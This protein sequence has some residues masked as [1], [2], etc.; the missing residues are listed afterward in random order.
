MD[1][2]F[3]FEG[4]LVMATLAEHRNTYSINTKESSASLN[5]S[6]ADGHISTQE[7]LSDTN[8]VQSTHKVSENSNG[9]I[10]K[11]ENRLTGKKGRVGNRRSGKS[12][13]WKSLQF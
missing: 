8:R 6:K 7:S 2:P 10:E 4:T 3:L 11:W 13:N 12:E 5:N 9:S 1:S